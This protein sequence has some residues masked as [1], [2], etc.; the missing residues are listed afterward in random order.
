[1]GMIRFLE[2]VQKDY[3][4]VLGIDD[5]FVFYAED[6]DQSLASESGAFPENFSDLKGDYQDL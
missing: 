1:M 2:K 6:E 3:E 4:I 5:V